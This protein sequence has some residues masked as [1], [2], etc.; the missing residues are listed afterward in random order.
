MTFNTQDNTHS[1]TRFICS[2]NN[3]IINKNKK[4]SNVNL[5]SLSNVQ[6][7]SISFKHE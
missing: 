1:Y 5:L 4:G 3:L 7:T 2:I 6:K